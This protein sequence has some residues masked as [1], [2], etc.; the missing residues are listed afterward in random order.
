[1]AF[2]SSEKRQIRS[3]L[4]RSG[5]FRDSD[6][7]LESMMDVVGAQVD[8]SAYARELLA[9]IADVDAS[10]AGSGS[11]SSATYGAV[12]KVDEIEFHPL[13]SG[14]SGTTTLSGVSYGE[15]LIERLRAL[16]GV[17]LTGRYFRSSACNQFF[18]GPT[19]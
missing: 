2:N 7:V 4:G 11:G 8:E 10:L 15:V 16:F 5:G 12:K 18:F 14:E 3:Y 13:S 17:E 1:M 9:S 6:Y 19:G